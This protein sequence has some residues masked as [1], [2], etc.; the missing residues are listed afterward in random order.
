CP[1]VRAGIPGS[2]GRQRDAFVHSAPLLLVH[3]AALQGRYSTIVLDALFANVRG[4]MRVSPYVTLIRTASPFDG[5]YEQISRPGRGYLE[6]RSGG[7]AWKPERGSLGARSISL[8]VSW[9]RSR[10]GTGMQRRSIMADLVFIVSRTE[11][12]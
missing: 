3:S 7:R 5:Q 4:G 9:S 11:P 6:C 2:I 8:S 12:K 1:E 10:P